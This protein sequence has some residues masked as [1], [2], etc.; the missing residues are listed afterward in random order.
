MSGHNNP[1]K[2][3]LWESLQINPTIS[4]PDIVVSLGTG[5]RAAPSPKTSSFRH[6]IFDGF[7]PRLWR[8]YMSSLD[9]QTIWQDFINRIEDGY[10]ADY[11][12]LN[13]RMVGTREPAIDDIA[14]MDELREIVR[15]QPRSIQQCRDTI[16]A[17]LVSSFYFELSS[18]PM[19]TQGRYHCQGVIRCRLEGS[20]TVQVLS[21]I[22]EGSL[23]FVTV[24]ENLGQYCGE[25]DLCWSC[26]Q[27]RKQ[28]DLSVRHPTETITLYLESISQGRRKISAFPQTVHWFMERQQIGSQFGTSD[29]DAVNN[30][31]CKACFP[32]LSNLKRRFMHDLIRDRTQKRPRLDSLTELE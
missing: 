22:H 18:A 26:G 4:K 9:G 13:V 17:L 8:S 23:V 10:R 29:H 1:I 32:G 5:T 20:A 30:R 21:R 28:I 16:F 7:I 2:I 3:A 24:S 27:Y 25:E 19:Y 14:S 15:A 12:R 6:V 31:R 11:I